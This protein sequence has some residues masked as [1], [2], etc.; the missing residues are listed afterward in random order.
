MSDDRTKALAEFRKVLVWVVIAAVAMVAGALAYLAA[1]GEVTVVMVLATIFGAFVS[2]TLGGALMAA[3]FFSDKS[4]HDQRI[5]DATKQ[6]KDP[7]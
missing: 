4:G 6:G 2:V 5:T 7:D 1:T 3:I